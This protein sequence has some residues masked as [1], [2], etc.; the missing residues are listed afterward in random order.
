MLHEGGIPIFWY[1]AHCKSNFSEKWSPNKKTVMDITIWAIVQFHKGPYKLMLGSLKKQI[2][3]IYTNL[4]QTLYREY[5]RGILP[6]LIYEV[7]II[8]ISNTDKNMMRNKNYR[9][10]FLRCTMQN[11]NKMLA[12]QIQQYNKTNTSRSSLIYF[13]NTKLA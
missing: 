5:K 13:R 12:T 10:V 2:D 3:K 4:S 8:L 11:P 9:P 6:I 7:N 1:F